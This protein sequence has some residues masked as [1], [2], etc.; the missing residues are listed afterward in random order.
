MSKYTDF[1]KAHIH[2]VPGKTMPD[3]MRAVGALWRR[4]KSGG[5]GLTPPGV[6]A[7]KGLTTPGAQAGRGVVRDWTDYGDKPAM[8][9]EGWKDD[10]KAFVKKGAKTVG[11][12]VVDLAFSHGAPAL[13]KKVGEKYPQAATLLQK[14]LDYGGVPLRDVIQKK[15]DGFGIRHARAHLKQ[16]M[17]NHPPKGKR[18]GRLGRTGRGGKGLSGMVSA[19]QMAA[20]RAHI[21]GGGA[22]THGALSD[23]L[24]GLTV[25]IS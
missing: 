21:K 25:K 18:G 5:K 19:K 3:K 10:L 24:K 8:D 13:I 1:V 17:E 22:V 23:L 7:G 9:G 14:A 16:H 15:I 11:K 2:K 20:L 12:K 6:H 4:Q